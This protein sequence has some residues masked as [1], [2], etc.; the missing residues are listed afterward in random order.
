MQVLKN[1]CSII[2]FQVLIPT[3]WH[4]E[5]PSP[6]KEKKKT[7]KHE[8]NQTE[9]KANKQQQI[10]MNVRLLQGSI[11]RLI[12]LPLSKEFLDSR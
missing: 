5:T 10:M 12:P 7:N 8:N 11:Q 2:V 4:Y 3:L 6:R 1:K 9:L